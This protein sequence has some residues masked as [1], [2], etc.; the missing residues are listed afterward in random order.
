MDAGKLFSLTVTPRAGLGRINIP[1]F[2]K[3][4]ADLL[5]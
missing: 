2:L 1:L 4:F 3:L 5:L